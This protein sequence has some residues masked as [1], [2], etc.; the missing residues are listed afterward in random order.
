MAHKAIIAK[1]QAVRDIPG[2]DKIHIAYVLGEE[3]IV[4]KEWGVDY[5]GAFFPV[6]L[7][8]SEQFCHHNNL[9]RDKTLN[10]DKEKAGFF[11]KSRRVRAQ[12]FLKVR[13][14]GFFASLDSLSW[15]GLAAEFYAVG[16]E[17]DELN[18]HKI[19]E[20]YVSEATKVARGNKATKAAKK[21][22]APDFQ[23]HVDTEQFKY[24]VD[25]I[26]P[27]S[28]VYI[29][30]KVHGT[31]ARMGYLPVLRDLPKWK[32]WWNEHIYR[33]TFK[34]TSEYDYVVGTR[35]VVLKPQDKNKEGFHGSEGYRFE[36]LETVKPFLKKG[37][38]IYGEIA[39]Y[40]NGSPI[41]ARHN[42][43]ATK[44][45]EFIKKYGKTITYSYGC[46]E[47]E[48]RFHI[49]RI[50]SMT[51][52]G[53]HI[54]WSQAQIDAFCEKTGIKGVVNLHGPLVVQ[55]TEQLADIVT[56]CTEREYNL[57]EDYIDPSHPSEGVIVRVEEGSHTPKFYKNKSY[58][59]KVME[60]ML[61]AEDTED[62]A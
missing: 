34:P 29:Q 51:T 1:I 47:H 18:G 56:R 53:E 2:A 35:N 8:L 24:Y 3:V 22:Y 48:Y 13:S 40:A 49:Y 62:A 42:A 30:A 32:Q 36:V 52:D 15:A 27:G 38:T 5:V 41:M 19:C 31:S 9:F 12:P 50:T 44:D 45:K 25:R 33:D 60:G 6:D 46:K 17:F 39:G 43:E 4:S 21:E 23:K 26:K 20:K 59:F 61:E 37:M 58:F 16:T 54:D 55:D 28:V 11:E 57:T 7:Q 14:T 10:K